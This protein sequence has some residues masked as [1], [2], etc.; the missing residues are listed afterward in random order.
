MERNFT[1]SDPQLSDVYDAASSVQVE[2]LTLAEMAQVVGCQSD[3]PKK[4]ADVVIG[5][6]CLMERLAMALDPVLAA[7]DPNGGVVTETRDSYLARHPELKV[8]RDA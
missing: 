2:L 5:M 6:G 8:V 7:M 3:D 1:I 4:A